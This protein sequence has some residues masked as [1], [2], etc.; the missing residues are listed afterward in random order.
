MRL[1]LDPAEARKA[2]AKAKAA[3]EV[4]VAELTARWMAEHVR[5]KLKPKTV[6]KYEQLLTRLILPALGDI[7]VAR[8]AV[9]DVSRFTLP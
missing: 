4:T 1:V 9:D 7:P 5:P 8:L 3:A 2:R 6:Y